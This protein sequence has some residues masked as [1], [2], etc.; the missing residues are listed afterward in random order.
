[1]SRKT[2][3]DSITQRCPKICTEYPCTVKPRA[4]KIHTCVRPCA[5]PC[6]VTPEPGKTHRCI[7][8][9]PDPCRR[10]RYS[11]YVDLR[12]NGGQPT[13]GG[14]ATLAEAKAYRDEILA[15]HRS[16][17][18]PTNLKLTV[19]EYLASWI[20]TKE[21][22]G[23]KPSTARGYRS[24]IDN[25]LVPYV[26]GRKLSELRPAHLNDM[27]VAIRA[28][29]GMS[30]ATVVNVNRTLKSALTSALKQGEVDRNVAMLAELPTTVAP[31]IQAWTIEQ[32]K[33]FLTT[34]AGHRLRPLFFLA[35]HTGLRRGELVALR[36]QDV[37]LDAGELIVVK[38]A[39]QVGATVVVGTPKTSKSKNRRVPL[40]PEVITVLK[41]Q[42]K[43]QAAARLAA[44]PAWVGG[45]DL[46]FTDQFGAMLIPDSVT[47]VFDRL[48]CDEKT[49]KARIEG[50]PRIPL[51]NLRHTALSIM[52]AKGVP[53]TL[54]AQI[55][56]HSDISITYRYY[57]KFLPDSADQFKAIMSGTDR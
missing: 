49:K 31:D 38:N 57:A 48:V 19:G 8:P 9:C 5:D 27:Y 53:I 34:L 13:K 25:Y 4:G 28:D 14:F 30:A 54:V 26:G 46:V 15:K 33:T 55:A 50:V 56:G 32:R 16:G 1:M 7:K 47:Q 52:V 20:A 41:G 22:N 39:V 43:T 40:T 3:H 12:P 29:R 44:G 36:W 45:E 35:S 18:L 37:D 24:H 2:R 11:V 51:K 23:L 10:H 17:T 21:A 6:T 42:R